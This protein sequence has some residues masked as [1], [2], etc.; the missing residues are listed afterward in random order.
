MRQWLCRALVVIGACCGGSLHAQS[1]L[2]SRGRDFADLV[3][4]ACHV[5]SERKQTPILR[6]PGP[7]FVQI[8]R[9]A[10]TTDGGLRAYLDTKHPDMGPSGRM[11]NPR[12]AD[13]QIDEVVAYMLSLRDHP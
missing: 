4:S 10:S 1:D 8:A 3:C 13:Y 11:P 5:V 12:L 2:V 7:A 9:R 6:D